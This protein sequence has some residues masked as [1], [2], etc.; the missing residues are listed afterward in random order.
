MILT[1][2]PWVFDPNGDTD[3]EDI[4]YLYKARE[5]NFLYILNI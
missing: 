4:T 5:G 1:K 3:K 2:A